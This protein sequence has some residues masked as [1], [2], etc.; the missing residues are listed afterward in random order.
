MRKALLITALLT[1]FTTLA[2]R[3]QTLDEI[4]VFAGMS[5]FTG[6]VGS[7]GIHAPQGY[8]VGASYRHQF[9]YHY[10]VRGQ[11]MY[12]MIANDDAL[13]QM[14]DRQARN[15]HFR[16]PVFEGA[17]IA[18]FNFFEYYTGSRKRK[19][20]PYI[21]AGFGITAFNPQAF[22]DGEWHNLQPLGTEGQRSAADPG[23]YYPTATWSIPFGMG[24]RWSIGDI[25]SVAIEVGFRRTFSDYI[26]DV[27]GVYADPEVV[28]NAHGDIAAAL[29][30]R[31]GR[32][33]EQIGY[34]RGNA[35]TDDWYTFTGIHLYVEL[36]P[37]VEKC[38]N[39]I[40]R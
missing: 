25:S 27:S 40:S 10:A 24:Y 26:D 2:Q 11:F 17:I 36:S 34:A 38:A 1:G 22:Y 35:A 15:L 12:G 13:S 16:S 33:V 28:R 6:D 30:N 21:F 5:H 32:A 3:A 23:N 19:H 4:G 7:Y 18:E 14:V 37:F 8:A 31:S 29:S 39:F 9:D 20:S